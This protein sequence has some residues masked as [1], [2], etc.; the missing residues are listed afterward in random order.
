VDDVGGETPLV[1]RRRVSRLRP[2]GPSGVLLG[3][4]PDPS[5]P[6]SPPRGSAPVHGTPD[7]ALRVRL[8]VRPAG[9][10]CLD[11]ST[12]DCWAAVG[13]GHTPP[14]S[15][16]ATRV[17][18]YTLTAHHNHTDLRDGREPIALVACLF[19]AVPGEKLERGD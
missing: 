11:A 6:S 2:A 18:S 16:P 12:A 3:S 19:A 1:G 8:D 5:A 7:L 4:L 17:S 9:S 14:T 13:A 15:P 10:G